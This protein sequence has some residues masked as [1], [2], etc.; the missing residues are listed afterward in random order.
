MSQDGNIWSYSAFL[1]LQFKHL[2]CGCS[3]K[4][5]TSCDFFFF[6]RVNGRTR[7]GCLF[8]PLVELISEQGT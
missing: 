2:L 4:K 3:F 1:L 6:P 8:S 7:N 5:L